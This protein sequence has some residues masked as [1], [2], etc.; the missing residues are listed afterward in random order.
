MDGI[1]PIYGGIGDN[2]S[3]WVYNILSSDCQPLTI[4]IYICIFSGDD[5][6]Y[7]VY[8]TKLYHLMSQFTTH[9]PRR[10]ATDDSSSQANR[11]LSSSGCQATWPCVKQYQIARDHDDDGGG[12]DAADDDDDDDDGDCD[13]DDG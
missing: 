12:G 11:H 2:L 5:H 4:I 8:H 9:I 3:Y 10:I 1:P 13:G 7:W 6:D